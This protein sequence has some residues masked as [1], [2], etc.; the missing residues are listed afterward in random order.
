M[1]HG[2]TDSARPEAICNRRGDGSWLSIERLLIEMDVEQSASSERQ[3]RT[4]E[5]RHTR[6]GYARKVDIAKLSM[7]IIS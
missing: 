3:V 2:A 5:E 1:A 7:T 6:S 4:S